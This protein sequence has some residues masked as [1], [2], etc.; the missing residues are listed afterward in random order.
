MRNATSQLHDA[1]VKHSVKHQVESDIAALNRK[2]ALMETEPSANLQ[3]LAAY[4]MM[5]TTRTEVL[6]CLVDCMAA[7]DRQQPH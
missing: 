2:I 4:R 7:G 1:S 3:L 6:K 5:L